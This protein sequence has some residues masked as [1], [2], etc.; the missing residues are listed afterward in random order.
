MA[1]ECSCGHRALSSVRAE[2]SEAAAS[3]GVPLDTLLATLNE[4]RKAAA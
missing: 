2:Q 4:A 1:H 3:A